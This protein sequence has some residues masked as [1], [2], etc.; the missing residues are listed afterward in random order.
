[1]T[2][3]VALILGDLEEYEKAEERLREAIKGY[4]IEFGE[5]KSM[6]KGQYGLTP[7]SWAA[8][9]GNDA[10]VDLLLAKDSIDPDLKDGCGQ[11]PLWRAAQNGHEA[12]VK[13]LRK[14]IN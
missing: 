14:Y 9:N 2:W 11:T 1:M 7:L 10:I 13:L 3:N 8:G 6:L 12:A 5:Q 4:E